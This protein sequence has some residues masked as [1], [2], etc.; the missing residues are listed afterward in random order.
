MRDEEMRRR[1]R[2]EKEWSD[3]KSRFAAAD[4]RPMTASY[5]TMQLHDLQEAGH[6]N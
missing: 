5:R 3:A 2:R 1:T 4:P 6:E